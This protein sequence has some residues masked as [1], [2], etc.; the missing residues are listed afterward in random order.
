MIDGRDGDVQI[1][2]LPLRPV[3]D[4]LAEL[5]LVE[6]TLVLVILVAGVSRAHS[7]FGGRCGRL[8]G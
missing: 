3:N 5:A 8:R 6:A 4:T 7:S 1:T 2:G